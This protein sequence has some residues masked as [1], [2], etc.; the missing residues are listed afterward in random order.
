MNITMHNSGHKTDYIP[1][2]VIVFRVYLT[3]HWLPRE[4]LIQKALECRN[5]GMPH[6][7][8]NFKLPNIQFQ[9]HCY[10]IHPWL[11]I[12]LTTHVNACN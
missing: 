7:S 3:A 9:V 5:S 10:C 2:A 12:T 1:K 8:V 6:I 4:D 11:L